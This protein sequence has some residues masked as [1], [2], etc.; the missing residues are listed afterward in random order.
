MKYI[1]DKIHY[2]T[3]IIGIINYSNIRELVELEY[4]YN[5]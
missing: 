3:Y 4:I 5:I 1:Q 2:I